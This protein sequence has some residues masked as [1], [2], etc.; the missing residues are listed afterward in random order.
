M[1]R[2]LML[3]TGP[4]CTRL[5][6]APSY[7]GFS[8]AAAPSTTR[9][10]GKSGSNSLSSTIPLEYCHS[11][12]GDGVCDHAVDGTPAHSMKVE[13]TNH[14]HAGAVLSSLPP[15]LL[16]S[17]RRGANKRSYRSYASPNRSDRKPSNAPN[18]SNTAKSNI[19][20][21]TYKVEHTKSNIESRTYSKNYNF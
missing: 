3:I 19:Q 1:S 17:E 6:A 2:Y 12:S 10:F 20:S 7:N 4:P 5:S 18:R 15:I 14:R 8:S 13:K 9:H 16:A 21:R 11:W